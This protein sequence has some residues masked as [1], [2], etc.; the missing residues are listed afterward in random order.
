MSHRSNGV[1]QEKEKCT[2]FVNYVNF[3]IGLRINFIAKKIRNE[4]RLCGKHGSLRTVQLTTCCA[5]ALFFNSTVTKVRFR[6]TSNAHIMDFE[7]YLL[8][9]L[10]HQTSVRHACTSSHASFSTW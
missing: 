2:S 10:Y 8:M 5:K 7:E 9:S 1:M 6:V 3:E 4:I